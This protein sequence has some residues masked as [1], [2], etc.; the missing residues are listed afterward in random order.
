MTGIVNLLRLMPSEGKRVRYPGPPYLLGGPLHARHRGPP[1]E[2]VPHL[3]A[4]LR[5]GQQMASRSEV[6]GDRSV[7]RQEALGM[8]R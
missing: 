1:L 7:R 4:G 5:R 8:T 2:A 6:L 3:L